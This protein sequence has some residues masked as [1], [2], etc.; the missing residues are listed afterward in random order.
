M[1]TLFMRERRL[2]VAASLLLVA[3]LLA[4][5]LRAQSPPVL[6][7]EQRAELSRWWE[8]QPTRNMPFDNNGAKVL[9]VE[10]TD[11]QC[12]HCRQK[13]L[14]LKPILAKYAG[15]P[16]DVALLLKHWPISNSCNPGVTT[17]VHPSACDAAAAVVMARRKGTADALVDW[18]FTHQDEMTP[19]TV[20]RAASEIGTISDFDAQYARAMLEVKT[21]IALG[22]ALGVNS[23]PGFFINARQLPAGGLPAQYFA[24][25]LD[26]EVGRSK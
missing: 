18:F 3:G 17:N 6:T 20:R 21:D 13:Y 2:P 16:K 26:L 24:A 12:P 23:T 25:I 5:H 8:Q 15:R 19:A 11:L 14:E 1:R 10:F 22:A 7:Q 4:P 9:I